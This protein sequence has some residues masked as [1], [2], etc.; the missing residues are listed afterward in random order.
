MTKVILSVKNSKRI[1]K[2][3]IKIP[4]IK[5]LTEKNSTPL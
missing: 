4:T 1:K 5:K 2:N 3:N